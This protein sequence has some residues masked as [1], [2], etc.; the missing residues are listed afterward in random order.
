MEDTFLLDGFKVSIRTIPYQEHLCGYIDFGRKLTK[1]EWKR[2]NEAAHG[3]ITFNEGT[4]YGFDCAHSGDLVPGIEN[5]YLA[6]GISNSYR[7]GKVYR[8]KNYVVNVLNEMI[9]AFKV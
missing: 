4:I 7:D 5:L 3:G 1:A 9:K 8:D 2:V 6:L